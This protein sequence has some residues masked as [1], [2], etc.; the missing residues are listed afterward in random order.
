M[1]RGSRDL[2]TSDALLLARST[3]TRV[4]PGRNG[5]KADV[6]FHE[7]ADGRRIVVKD[8]ALRPAWIRGT[9][10]RFLVAREC[11]AYA[12]AGGAEGL[13]AFLGRVGAH[14]LALEAIDGTPLSSLGAERLEPAVFDRLDAIVAGLHGRGIAIADLHH[15]DVL[16]GPRGVFVVDLATAWA[17]GERPGP[18]RRWIFRRL[19]MQDRL[20]A[21]RLRARF[22]GVPE[23]EALASIPPEARRAHARGRAV[24][25]VWD[26]FRGRMG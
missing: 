7:L 10:G 6:A 13:P 21:A 24:K 12:H 1:S 5:T 18:L 26:R 14:A 23:E 19:A 15:R 2:N 25:R 16:V 3:P 11:R 9:L 20:A 8:Y 17:L 22:T 4:L